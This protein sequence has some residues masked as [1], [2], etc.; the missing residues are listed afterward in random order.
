MSNLFSAIE[1][2]RRNDGIFEAS[3]LASEIL[4]WQSGIDNDNLRGWYGSS[5]IAIEKPIFVTLLEVGQK[6][7][8]HMNFFGAT[9]FSNV[10]L[11]SLKVGT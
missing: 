7:G 2:V 5:W 8:I 11:E 9:S 6:L 1:N 10:S 4:K 3:N